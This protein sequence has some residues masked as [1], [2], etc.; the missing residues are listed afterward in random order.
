M[1]RQQSMKCD[2]FTMSSWE[3]S[4]LCPWLS[5]G[6][7]PPFCLVAPSPPC[8]TVLGPS[9]ATPSAP[10]FWGVVGEFY[11]VA[12]RSPCVHLWL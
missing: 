1:N 3:I 7:R 10:T 4:H 8:Q 9:N 5:A 6:W 12:L 2:I 11:G